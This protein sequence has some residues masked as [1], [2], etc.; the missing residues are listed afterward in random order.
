[1]EQKRLD[2]ELQ[3][4]HKRILPAYTEAHAIHS[5][6][7]KG[8]RPVKTLNL[9]DGHKII[10]EK[11]VGMGNNER[12]ERFE[13][14]VIPGENKI[15]IDGGNMPGNYCRQY[16]KKFQQSMGDFYSFV[17][18]QADQGTSVKTSTKTL[19]HQKIGRE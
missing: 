10:L 18:N 19:Q 7:E 17:P 16:S 1:M 5:L 12:I 14:S 4:I 3:A 6:E 13:I 8:F 15:L 2:E 9:A 11:I